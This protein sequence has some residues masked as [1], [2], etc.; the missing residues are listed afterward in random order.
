[1]KDTGSGRRRRRRRRSS[2]DRRRRQTI[3]RPDMR[4]KRSQEMKKVDV[5]VE[6]RDRG[7]PMN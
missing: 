5:T 4:K 6:I 2:G 3:S 1:V 7:G